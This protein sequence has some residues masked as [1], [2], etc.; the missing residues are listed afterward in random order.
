M[1]IT[2]LPP[3][4]PTEPVTPVT[5]SGQPL[6]RGMKVVATVLTTGSGSGTQLSLFGRHLATDTPLPHPPGSS[7]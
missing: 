2:L 7:L 1:Q 3:L 4:L 6:V 5:A